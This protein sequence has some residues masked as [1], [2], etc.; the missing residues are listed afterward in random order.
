M[1]TCKCWKRWTTVV[2]KISG[3][4]HCTYCDLPLPKEKQ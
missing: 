1:E 3:V 4:W 2:R